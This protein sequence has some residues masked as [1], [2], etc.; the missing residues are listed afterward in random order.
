MGDPTRSGPR[1]RG[2]LNL[3]IYSL[4]EESSTLINSSMENVFEQLDDPLRLSAH[5][6][7]PSWKM[8]WGKMKTVV[9]ALDGR[10]VGSHIGLSGQIFGIQL[11]LEEMVILREPP[12]T[13][14][15][16]TVGEP[17]LIVI[18]P[19]RMGFQLKQEM[20]T[21]QLRVTI[22]YDL[23]KKGVPHLLGLLFGRSYAK[24]CTQQMAKDAHRIFA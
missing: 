19:Y 7:K 21:V 17:N 23:P 18:G 9:D 14:T 16:E 1:A 15:W 13:K 6:S 22:D 5:M 2:A 24:W 11:D 20:E 4:H 8:G 10:C 12:F 3:P